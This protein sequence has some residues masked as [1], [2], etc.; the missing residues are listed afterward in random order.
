M[1]KF[2]G[3]NGSTF[4]PV[5]I[6]PD[7]SGNTWVAGYYNFAKFTGVVR[8]VTFTSGAIAPGELISIFGTNLGPAQA[9]GG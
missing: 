6:A 7:A 5:A 3:K 2:F 4:I 8:A 1:R 9:Q